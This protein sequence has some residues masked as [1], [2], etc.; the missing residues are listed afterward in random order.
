MWNSLKTTIRI[1]RKSS[2]HK[3]FASTESI[4]FQE[5]PTGV[6]PT[7]EKPCHDTDMTSQGRMN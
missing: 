6:L 1:S 4:L 7:L 5:Y 2:L 3:G